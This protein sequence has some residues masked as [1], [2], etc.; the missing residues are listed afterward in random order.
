MMEQSLHRE[1]RLSLLDRRGDQRRSVARRPATVSASSLLTFDPAV[2]RGSP[3]WASPFVALVGHSPS[4]AKT[5]HIAPLTAIRRIV[6]A[7]RLWRERARSRQ[8]LRELSNYM[9]DDIGLRR[10]ALG[11]EFQTP[12]RR[13]DRVA[14]SRGREIPSLKQPARFS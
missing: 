1:Y 11:Y 2:Q 6:A 3:L 14:F 9:L 12:F 13:P 4:R 8:Q 10:D 7:I 5:R